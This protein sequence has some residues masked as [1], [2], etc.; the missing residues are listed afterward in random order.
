MS[1]RDWKRYYALVIQQ[2]DGHV[3]LY[4]V[5]TAGELTPYRERETAHGSVAFVRGC[6][7]FSV[8]G[9]VGIRGRKSHPE[10]QQH[11]ARKHI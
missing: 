10:I 1:A 11:F 7:G 6:I 8:L 4:P 9:I 3:R 2:P 5:N